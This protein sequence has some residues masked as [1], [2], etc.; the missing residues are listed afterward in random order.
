MVQ[1]LI[2]RT[3]ALEGTQRRLIV[4]APQQAMARNVIPL[5]PRDGSRALRGRRGAARRGEN[6]GSRRPRET[7]RARALRRCA[8]EAPLYASMARVIRRAARIGMR[9]GR[10]R[11]RRSDGLVRGARPLGVGSERGAGLPRSAVRARDVRR[12]P[13][14]LSCAPASTS[15]HSAVIAPYAAVSIVTVA[16]SSR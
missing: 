9:I 11:A 7:T 8:S 13:Q 1:A 2:I 14:A 15:H 10:A 3:W 16:L 6:G 4:R 5:A 12:Q